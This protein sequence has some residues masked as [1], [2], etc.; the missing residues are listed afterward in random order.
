MLEVFKDAADCKYRRNVVTTFLTRMNNGSVT[1]NARGV[2]ELE[3]G[4]PKIKGIL[5]LINL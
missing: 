4:I 2:V 3:D 5:K 1:G